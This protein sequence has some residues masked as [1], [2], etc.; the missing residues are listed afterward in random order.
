RSAARCCASL[1]NP[2]T[3]SLVETSRPIAARIDHDVGVADLLQLAHDGRGH[4]GFERAVELVFPNLD[5][6]V[7]V[8]MP[9][10]PD[11][12]A[13]RRNGLLGALDHAQ[14]LA[15]HFGVVRNT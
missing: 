15:R 5:A 13:H 2:K 9:H 14:L 8:E 6:G 1:E 11:P 7:S 12:K 3:Q 10:A 4:A